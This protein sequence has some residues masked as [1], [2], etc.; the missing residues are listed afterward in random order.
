ME[1]QDI[2]RLLDLLID[3]KWYTI[4][5][6]TDKTRIEEHKVKLVTSFLREFQF[7]RIDKKTGRI[8]LN[9]S[10]KEFLEKLGKAD[11]NSSYEEITA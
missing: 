2:D 1:K 6:I 9:T 4:K 3:G 8:R 11:S 10:T 5:E 7:A